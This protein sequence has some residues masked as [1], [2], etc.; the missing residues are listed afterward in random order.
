MGMGVM[1]GERN[2]ERLGSSSEEKEGRKQLY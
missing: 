2:N 1:K